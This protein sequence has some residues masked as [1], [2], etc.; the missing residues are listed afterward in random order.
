MYVFGFKLCNQFQ[1][2][3]LPETMPEC[4]RAVAKLKELEVNNTMIQLKLFVDNAE[5]ILNQA[6]S[7]DIPLHD[8]VVKFEMQLFPPTVQVMRYTEFYESPEA[9]KGFEDTRSKENI[10]CLYISYYD[11]GGRNLS[12]VMQRLFP[13]ELL[14]GNLGGLNT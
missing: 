9:I 13:H 2:R 8:C 10:T 4:E 6:S 1:G 5:A 3:F 14:T 12:F 11:I 7:L